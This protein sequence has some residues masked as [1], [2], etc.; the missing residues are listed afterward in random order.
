MKIA[1]VEWWPRICGAVS[2]ALHLSHARRRGTTLDR[3]TFSASGRALAAWDRANRWQVHRIRDAVEVLNTYDLVILSDVVCCAP[4]TTKNPYYIEIL[5]RLAT[6]WTAMVHDGAYRSKHDDTLRAVLASPSFTGTLITTRLPD[7]RRRLDHLASPHRQIRWVSYPYLPYSLTFQPPPTVRIPP[8]NR[9]HRTFLMTSRIA[10]NK[11]QNIAMWLAPKLRARLLMYGYNAFG[12]PSIGW[13]LWELANALGY[14]VIRPP[15]LRR[16]ATRLTHPRAARFYTGAFAV[17]HAGARIEYRDGFDELADIDWGAGAYHLSLSNTS[18]RGTLEYVTLEAISAGA[19]AVVPE[20]AIELARYPSGTFPTIPYTRGVAWSRDD[21]TARID[22]D[23]AEAEAMCARLT[24][25]M[26][27]HHGAVAALAAAQQ[28]EL[29][30][31]HDPNIVFSKLFDAVRVHTARRAA[32]RPASIVPTANS[33]EQKLM[34]AKPGPQ[35]KGKLTAIG[36]DIFAGGFTVGVAQHFHVA[37]HL[38][39]DD[40]GTEVARANF[41]ALPIFIGTE[42]WPDLPRG[43]RL[44]FL[45]SN[46]PCAIWS[47][48]GNR[49][50]RIDWRKDPR[51]QRIRNIHGLIARYKPSVWVWE[52]VCQ[53]FERGREFVESLADAA[54]SL[55]YSASYV[56][57]DAQYLRAPQTRKRFFLV[58]HRI[59]IDWLAAR[60]NFDAKPMTIGDAL[61]GVKPNKFQS[62]ISD[63]PIG[64]QL[65][66]LI[67]MTAPGGRLARTYEDNPKKM[68]KGESEKKTNYGKPSFLA[69]RINPDTVAGVVFGDKTFHH[70]EPRHLALNELGA[71]HGFPKDYDWVGEHHRLDVQRGVLPPVAEW[72][73]RNV[74]AACRRGTVLRKPTRSLVDFRRAPGTI[75]SVLGLPAGVDLDWR[76]GETPDAAADRAGPTQRRTPVPSGGSP[77]SVPGGRRAQGRSKAAFGGA[78]SGTRDALRGAESLGD[79]KKAISDK[80]SRV[81]RNPRAA[82]GSRPARTKWTDPR[83]GVALTSGEFIRARLL[84][85]K[86]GDQAIADFVLARFPGRRTK[87]SDVAWNRR[88]IEQDGGPKLEKLG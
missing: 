22:I 78:R 85:R 46:P 38:E 77:D 49:D 66:R 28:R 9:D 15:A 10:V 36:A 12:L 54:A 87:V 81:N 47:L 7:A 88:K 75:Q 68:L 52:S 25:L 23:S 62:R 6:P 86:Y 4:A 3:V 73:A 59:A 11:G 65:R 69:Y 24:T 84:E 19:I 14:R 63:T 71:I 64:K 70:K 60:P 50:G 8:R 79:R 32:T 37:G 31:K 48:A 35:Q 82:L 40:Y 44:D 43:Q 39:H 1:V 58:L 27:L 45:Y 34:S 33:K 26:D 21:G 42:T 41:P 76:P 67:S 55:G 83:T 16:D 30:T 53:A 74:A 56:L 20:H 72:L 29:R 51:L 5:N 13:R 18:V 57:V 80:I 61:K 2:W 17:A